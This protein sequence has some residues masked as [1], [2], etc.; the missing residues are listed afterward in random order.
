M[1]IPGARTPDDLAA[2]PVPQQLGQHI[3]AGNPRGDAGDL[4]A[5][6]EALAQI[7]DAAVAGNDLGCGSSR[8]SSP[9]W[10]AVLRGSAWTVFGVAMVG[11]L[12]L[13]ALGI[14]T[15]SRLP[16]A[17]GTTW[18]GFPVPGFVPAAGRDRSD[19]PYR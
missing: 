19:R 16:D 15:R 11:A 2:R 18:G 6:I 10:W 3:R 13:L 5:D 9:R 4:D 7:I 17:A 1:S 14:L 12:W 8:R